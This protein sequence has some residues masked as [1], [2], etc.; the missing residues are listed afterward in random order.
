[1][2]RNR[3]P[4]IVIWLSLA[5]I[6][7]IAYGSL[8]PFNL[9][10]L[11]NT[12]GWWQS[13]AQALS[14]LTW[15]RA[16]YSDRLAN[17]LLYAPLGFCMALWFE[18]AM[19]RRVAVIVAVLCG[20]L[21]SLSIE[22]AQV[23]I[24]SRVPSFWDVTFNTLGT[25]V[26]AF[27]GFA[28]RA[29]SARLP[30][31]LTDA[32]G[33]G[34]AAT[35]MVLLLWFAW[36]LAPFIPRFSLV[37]LKSSLQPLLSPDVAL[38]PTLGYL[39]WW[40]VIAQIVFALTSAQRGVEL[41]LVTIA[42]VLVGRLFVA[43]LAFVPSE[44]LA[45]V[46]LLPTLVLLHRLWAPSRR[47]LLLIAFG[48]ACTFER[49]A[50]FTWSDANAHFDL[51]PFLAWFDAGLPIHL[52]SLC[53]MSFEFAALAW[54]LRDVG[55][56]MR[57]IRWLLPTAVLIF[58]VLALWMPGREGSITAPV[59]ALVVVLAMQSLG[60]DARRSGAIPQRVRNR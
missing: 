6:A 15:A 49:L 33:R 29:L 5:M 36:R 34:D 28:W 16:G 18:G 26:G 31:A 27:A 1:M 20:G 50:P 3:S 14:Q 56:A 37:K 30:T 59:L 54:L 11:D 55:M 17:V 12:H 44:L 7:L 24:S 40:S 58:E 60:S 48:G 25:F 9:K 10:P 4:A 57:F 35:L 41:L 32:S 53:K 52:Q 13:L 19:R 42:A 46:L 23:F 2:A 21:L 51:W 43:D 38:L 45:L 8:Y 22:V 39:I 47:L